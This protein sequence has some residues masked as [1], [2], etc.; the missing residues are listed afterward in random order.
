MLTESP[1]RPARLDRREVQEWTDPASDLPEDAVDR[2]H[3]LTNASLYWLTR[4][5]ESAANLYWQNAHDPSPRARKQRSEV[6]TGVAV[7][8]PAPNEAAV[9]RLAEPENT[10]V[11]WSEFDRGG[12]KRRPN[13]TAVCQ[14]VARRY[15]LAV[16]SW[17]PSS[18]TTT[19]AVRPA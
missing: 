15:A 10:I 2:D 17:P 18:L 1:D 7:F 6:P 11:H 8:K 16:S 4:T 12:G 19:A 14:P 13:G 9:R 5:A 3:L